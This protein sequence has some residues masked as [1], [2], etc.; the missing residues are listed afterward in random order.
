MALFRVRPT[1]FDHAVADEISAHTSPAIEE[2]AKVLTWGA[3]EHV[4][5]LAAAAFWLCS[6]KA[7]A[8]QRR[9]ANHALACTV[10]VSVLPHVLKML[11]DQER[12]DRQIW[13]GHWRGVPWSGKRYDAFPSGHA[14]HIG[15]LA[16]AATMFTWRVR[17]ALWSL[18]SLLAAT[19]IALLA[20]WPSDVLAGLALGALTERLLR[21]VTLARPRGNS[22]GVANVVSPQGGGVPSQGSARCRTIRLEATR[23][24]AAGR[25]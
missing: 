5:L 1:K 11:I 8:R 10:A 14:V 2:A 23:R 4:I 21:R 25:R 17:A 6:R 16:G 20:H 18:G 7:S 19:R 9:L 3:D 24:S 22:C 15:A 13:L 12:P